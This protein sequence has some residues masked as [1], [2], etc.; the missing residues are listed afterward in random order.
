MRLVVTADL[1][2]NHGRSRQLA[3]DAIAEINRTPGDVLLV[4]GDTATA[5]GD[6]LERALG[7]IQFDGPK[8]FVAGNHELWTKR[9]DSYAIFKD[10]LPCRVA[11][12]G[13]SSLEDNPFTLGD[14][15][16][17]GTIGWYDYSFAPESLGV[18]KRFY[19]AKVSP[20]AAEQL[21]EHKN[22]IGDDVPTH[23]REIMARWNDGKFIK[24]GRSD[25]AFLEERLASLRRSLGA[26]PAT[27]R[28][29][30]AVHHVPFH[31]L[32][33]PRH[34]ATWD[35]ARAYLGTDRIGDVLRADPRITHV[36]CGHSHSKADVRIDHLR[37]INIGS[38]Y[39]QKRV[40]AVEV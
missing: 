6:E 23:A 26:V 2:I 17:V 12:L 13:W 3:L 4:V 37:A 14:I 22:L 36:F 34:N 5:D 9:D 1:H 18:P 25:E 33:P 15:A 7:A 20:G 19:E 29:I 38:G 35:F 39:R 40:L 30:A 10:E 16:I 11:E 27:S 28:I 8:L 21:S 32:L 31:E 24:L